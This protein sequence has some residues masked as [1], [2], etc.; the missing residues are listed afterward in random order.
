MGTVSLSLPDSTH[1]AA[2]L[3]AEKEHISI[4]QLVTLA[5]AEKLSALEAEE[6]L[7]R[8]AKHGKREKFLK[9]LKDAPNIEPH[10]GD[11]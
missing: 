6:Y 4:N 7:S 9:V 3:L 8:R 2:K 1:K 11:H 10:E 5:I